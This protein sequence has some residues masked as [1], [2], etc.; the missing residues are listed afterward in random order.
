MKLCIFPKKT[1]EQK[2][3]G[4]TDK[5]NAEMAAAFAATPYGERIV[6][7]PHCMRNIDK[8][9]AKEMGSYYVCAECGACKIGQIS[10]K[11]KNSVTKR[12]IY[13]KAGKRSKDSPKN[14][15]PGPY[16]VSPATSRA[17]WAWKSPKGTD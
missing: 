2:N 6:F 12:Y 16:S 13:L 8:C 10:R 15:S 1:D 9:K 17:S 14:S 5:K 7:V 3:K 11:S 4:L